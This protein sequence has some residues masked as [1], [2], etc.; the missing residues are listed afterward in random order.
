[1]IKKILILT[2]LLCT[3]FISVADE[4]MAKEKNCFACHQMEKKLVGPSFKQISEKYQGDN[5]AKEL[6]TKKVV[7]GSS[8]VWG[9][10]PMPANKITQQEA[11][12]LI[13]WILNFKS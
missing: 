4:K 3:S 13:T 9:A 2:T 6:L 1:M 12:Q 11:D 8:G 7:G 5:K 10:V